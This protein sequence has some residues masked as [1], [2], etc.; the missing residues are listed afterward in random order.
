MRENGIKYIRTAAYHQSFNGQ[1]E[2]YVQTIKWVLKANIKNRLQSQESLDEFL[3][4]YRT[5]PS[6]VTGKTPFQMYMGRDL[7]T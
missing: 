4:A 7:N 5:T 1:V 3:M 2:R 6:T